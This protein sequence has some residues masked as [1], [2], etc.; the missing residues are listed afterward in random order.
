[1]VT[2]MKEGW[3]SWT[4]ESVHVPTWLHLWNDH[5]IEPCRTE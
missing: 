2:L 3:G 4:V 1:L 5:F